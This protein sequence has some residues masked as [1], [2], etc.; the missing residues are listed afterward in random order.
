MTAGTADGRLRTLLLAHAA[1]VVFDTAW[2]Y[3][4]YKYNLLNV[5]GGV[6]EVDRWMRLGDIAMYAF[7]VSWLVLAGFTAWYLR[8]PRPSWPLRI[9]ASSAAVLLPLA[10]MFMASWLLHFGFPP[11]PPI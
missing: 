4:S 3:T 2:A 11:P 5:G 7:L 6:G 9:L 8:R 1:A 10:L